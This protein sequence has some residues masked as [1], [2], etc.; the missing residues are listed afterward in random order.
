MNTTESPARA[1]A[2][3]DTA[4]SLAAIAAMAKWLAD[5]PVQLDRVWADKDN[6]D[7]SLAVHAG[8]GN[9]SEVYLS[10]AHEAAKLLLAARDIVIITDGGVS[11]AYWQGD[12]DE[13]IHYGPRSNLHT[14][15]IAETTPASCEFQPGSADTEALC[16]ALIAAGSRQIDA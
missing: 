9:W 5:D 11:Q 15:F 13:Y 1:T 12:L 7:K 14:D 4:A 8:T 10:T 6:V 16:T 3:E 2:T